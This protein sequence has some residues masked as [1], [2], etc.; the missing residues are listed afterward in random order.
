MYGAVFVVD[1]SLY[2]KAAPCSV[3]CVHLTVLGTVGGGLASSAHEWL[4]QRLGAVAAQRGIAADAL[5]RGQHRQVTGFERQHKPV[6]V[7]LDLP[8]P[9]ALIKLQDLSLDVIELGL[10]LERVE[11]DARTYRGRRLLHRHA[12]GCLYSCS[13]SSPSG[14]RLRP[15]CLGAN[16]TSLN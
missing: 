5:G 16:A 1:D 8:A 4:L 10:L 6:G 2:C 3:C 13:S 15:A 9:R 12:Q 11:L 7:Q 14:G